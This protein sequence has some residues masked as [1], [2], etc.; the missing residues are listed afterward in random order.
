MVP[1]NGIVIMLVQIALAHGKCYIISTYYSS[2]W[3]LVQWFVLFELF[4]E[5]FDFTTAK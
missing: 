4:H 1:T 5:D 3:C 2:I